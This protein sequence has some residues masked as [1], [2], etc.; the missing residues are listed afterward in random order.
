MCRKHLIGVVAMSA[1]TRQ[2]QPDERSTGKT[3]LPQAVEDKSLID[4]FTGFIQD[5]VPQVGEKQVANSDHN[6]GNIRTA[7]TDKN[8]CIFRAYVAS[9]SS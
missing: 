1:E 6:M 2:R 5:V 7:Y 8:Y 3:V 9:F 4:S